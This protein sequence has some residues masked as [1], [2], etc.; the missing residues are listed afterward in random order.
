M[1]LGQYAFAGCYEDTDCG[2]IG[3]HPQCG[4][5]EVVFSLLDHDSHVRGRYFT[6][7]IEEPPFT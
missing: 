7:G 4:E 6:V 5:S 3:L 1:L 2:I